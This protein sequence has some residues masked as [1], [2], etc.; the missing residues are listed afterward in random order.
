[1]DQHYR[2]ER[3]QERTHLSAP[4]PAAG[5]DAAE[6]PVTHPGREDLF[7]VEWQLPVVTRFPER[8]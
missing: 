6:H 5:D 1:M 7:L 2:V 4:Q 8:A 3:R